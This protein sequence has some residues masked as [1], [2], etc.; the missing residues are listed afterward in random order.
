MENNKKNILVVIK[1]I[2]I[3][4]LYLLVFC[5][6]AVL[7][8]FGGTI[9]ALFARFEGALLSSHFFLF[10]MAAELILFAL[11]YIYLDKIYKNRYKSFVSLFCTFFMF[12]IAFAKYS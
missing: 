4:T 12:V 11:N 7:S 6:S 2:F 9:L 3:F 8:Y 5:A 1:K 10:T